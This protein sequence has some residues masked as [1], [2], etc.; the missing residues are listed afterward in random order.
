M[1]LS[2]HGLHP[3]PQTQVS[4]STRIH[5]DLGKDKFKRTGSNKE[6]FCLTNNDYF[7]GD[8]GYLVVLAVLVVMAM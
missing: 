3:S 4:M 5:R 2:I 8:R 1:E 7:V 6:L